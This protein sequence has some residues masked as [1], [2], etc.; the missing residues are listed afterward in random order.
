MRGDLDRF[1]FEPDDLVVI[2]GQDGLVANVSKYLDGQPVVGIN[3][4]LNRTTAYWFA[5]LPK[6]LPRCYPWRRGAV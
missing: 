1:L 3:P 2:V 5:T 6:P 4:I